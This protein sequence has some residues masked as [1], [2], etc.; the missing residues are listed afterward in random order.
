[1]YGTGTAAWN[2][3]NPV[4]LNTTHSGTTFSLRDPT[5]TNLSCQNATGNTV[6]SGTDDVWG[7]GVATDRETGCVDAL[8]AAQ[9][10]VKMLS[11]WLGRNAMDGAGGAWPIRVGLNDLNAFYDGTQVQ[12]G[13]NQANQWI[14]SI[15]VL[16]HEMGHGIDDHTPGGISGNGTQEFVADTFGAGTE[17][18]AN[19]PAPF[20]TARWLSG[21]Q[22]A[23]DAFAG[24]HR[25]K[26][27]RDRDGNPV[28]LA[29]S[30]WDVNYQAER[31]PELTFAA[32][33][34]R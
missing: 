9:T 3:P 30:V 28:F 8:F 20:D 1:M 11:Q 2:G 29:Q 17:W 33:R 12:I 31:H 32:T 26:L 18:F 13:H 25:D 19:E 34:E 4:P 23:L 6:F 16:A 21:P 5:V 22:A 15:D 7:S 27:A 14:G 10:E 24:F